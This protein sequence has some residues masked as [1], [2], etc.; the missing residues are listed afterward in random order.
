MHVTPLHLDRMCEI[1]TFTPPQHPELSGNLLHHR[2]SALID[3]DSA[4]NTS[5]LRM[6]Y[7]IK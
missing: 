6:S 5:G 3:H 7:T 2:L 1:P 4:H